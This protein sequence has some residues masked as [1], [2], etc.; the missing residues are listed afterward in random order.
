VLDGVE[1]R[2]TPQ[3]AEPAFVSDPE[4]GV[5]GVR[6]TSFQA[7][8]VEHASTH[9]TVPMLLLNLEGG[10]HDGAAAVT[11][12]A[13]L[14]VTGPTEVEVGVLGVGDWTVELDGER[15]RTRLS[16][17][18]DLGAAVLDP[19]NWTTRV[20]VP[21]GAR[22]TAT[23]RPAA[24]G[25]AMIGLV[26]RRVPEPDDRLIAAAA[27]A[28]AGAH[29]AVVVVGLTT[30]QETE[31]R[32]KTTLALPGRQDELVE[33]VAAAARST[34]VV[35]NAATPVLMPWLERVDAVLWTGLPGQ[36]GGHAVADVLLGRREATGRL[37]TTFPAA[38]GDGPAWTPVPTDG[39][40]AYT[41]ADGVGYRGWTG[42][43][44]LFWFGH[45]L[46]WTTW[47]YSDAH[48]DGPDAL[49]VTVE[50]TGD[51]PGREVVQV[52][53]EPPGERVR[54]AGWAVVDGVAAG[55]RRTVR[56]PLDPRA[57]GRW[58]DLG[59][60]PLTGGLLLVARGLGDV[61]CKVDRPTG[62]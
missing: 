53:L 1:V 37:V 33:A 52:Y 47:A 43:P 15:H 60:Q 16:A 58:T 41:E 10:P 24:A 48:A 12:A 20:T 42:S 25:P 19:P 49:T 59:R 36:E 26:A 7:D 30:E 4:T 46:G 34:V 45:G 23:W 29:R 39:V 62:R 17:G 40:L 51:R 61:R 9:R 57:S 8:G 3:P 11:L 13:D 21:A 35:V 27:A 28:A 54:L 31:A 56:V 6:V 2:T 22:L 32:D 14:A 38:D 18:D 50:N 5:P 44:P 55:E